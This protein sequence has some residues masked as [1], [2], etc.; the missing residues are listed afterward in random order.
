MTVGHALL[1]F[2]VAAGL[3]TITPGLDS[4][5]VLRTAAVEGP[6]R[7]MMAGAGV[8][9]GLLTWGFDRYRSSSQ[10]FASRLQ[11][12]RDFRGLLPDFSRNENFPWAAFFLFRARAG[13]ESAP[14]GEGQCHGT[15]LVRSWVSDEYPEPES[16][17]LLHNVPSPIH[18]KRCC[19]HAVQYASRGN[20]GDAGN[21]VVL[22]FDSCDA[23]AFYV[24]SA[25]ESPQGS[26]SNDWRGACELWPNTDSGHSP[27]R[28]FA[29]GE[30]LGFM[31]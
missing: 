7:A 1:A 27:L 21:Y 8:C 3:L 17:S 4:A 12:A 5:L 6:R 16:R 26:R 22:D 25:P 15:A 31:R 14:S 9:L 10:R 19:R 29:P 24:A 11:R 20:S 2:T 13:T 23:V 18:S 30:S 28:L